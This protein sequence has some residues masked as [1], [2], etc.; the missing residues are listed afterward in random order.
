MKNGYRWLATA[1]LLSFVFCQVGCN[2]KHENGDGHAH[3]EKSAEGHDDHRDENSG[4]TYQEGKGISLSEETRKSL[5]LELAEVGE[6]EL[7]PTL[8]LTAQIYRAATE[9]SRTHGKERAGHAYATTLV[10]LELKD[11]LATGKKLS[12]TLQNKSEASHEGLVWLINSTQTA[13]LGKVE[14]LLEFPDG[15]HS[16]AVGDFVEAKIPL[17]KI[18]KTLSIPRSA[19]LETSTGTYAFVQNGGFLLRTEIKIGIQTDDTVE[20]TEGLYDGDTIV[21]KPVE[22]L[23]LIELRATKGGGHCH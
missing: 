11:K 21:V 12:F 15:D 22:A 6:R 23:Y 8:S 13:L 17:G 19:L 3:G 1:L 5:G 2:S 7:S 14:I 16:L 4:A 9:A 18:R 10:P 20:I